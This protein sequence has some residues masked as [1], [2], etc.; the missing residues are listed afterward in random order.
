MLGAF[1]PRSTAAVESHRRILLRVLGGD[2]GHHSALDPAFTF[3]LE[4]EKV[5]GQ[6][7]SGLGALSSELNMASPTAG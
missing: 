1:L 5:I 7:F 4:S 2:L 3:D 6:L